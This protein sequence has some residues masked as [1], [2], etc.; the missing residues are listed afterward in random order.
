MERS[1]SDAEAGSVCTGA[2]A[3]SITS[4]YPK[5]PEE[6][7]TSSTNKAGDH[8]KRRSPYTQR[9][10]KKGKLIGEGERASR[11]GLQTQN[12]FHAR[13]RTEGETRK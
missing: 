13:R 8:G 4:L 3:V 2:H 12:T 11:T 7:P 1:R 9:G 10:E 6:G 5:V